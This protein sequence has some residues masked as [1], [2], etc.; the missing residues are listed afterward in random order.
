MDY[1][2]SYARGVNAEGILSETDAGLKY[3]V[4]R[5]GLQWSQAQTILEQP[6]WQ[7]AWHDWAEAN[8]EEM[9]AQGQWGVPSLRYGELT[10]W[11]QDRIEFIEQAIRRHLG[12][13]D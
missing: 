9:I 2:L 13:A 8:R 7:T 5:A 3:I 1:L 12:L 10:L 4:E 11:G 6:D